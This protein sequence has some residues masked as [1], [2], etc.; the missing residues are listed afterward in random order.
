MGQSAFARAALFRSS[1]RAVQMLLQTINGPG[2]GRDRY[3]PERSERGAWHGIIEFI[4][5]PC[6]RFPSCSLIFLNSQ[7]ARLCSLILWRVEPDTRIRWMANKVCAQRS[8]RKSRTH[9]RGITHA[10]ARKRRIGERIAA[11]ACELVF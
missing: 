4:F 11:A 9:R 1:K 10:P 7:I 8:A 6:S 5:L 3:S 2:E